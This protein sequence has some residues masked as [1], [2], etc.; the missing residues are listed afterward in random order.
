MNEHGILKG[1]EKMNV[2]GFLFKQVAQPTNFIRS[3][4]ETE[5]SGQALSFHALFTNKLDLTQTQIANDDLIESEAGDIE[6]LL[7]HIFSLFLDSE[8]LEKLFEDTMSEDEDIQGIL[9]LLPNELS[10]EERLI[11]SAKIDEFIQEN[12]Q[13]FN[14]L[15]GGSS[16]KR[17]LTDSLDIDLDVSMENL[18]LVPGGQLVAKIS[19]IPA[20]QIQKQF[21]QIFVEVEPILASVTNRQEVMKVSSKI[22]K[23]LEN[24][25]TL[26]KK[27]GTNSAF[28]DEKA[29][30]KE[31]RSW[32]QLIKTFQNRNQFVSKQQYNRSA[33][34]SST[35]IA[36][37]VTS[38]LGVEEASEVE[39]TRQHPLQPSATNMPI[40]KLEQ[41]VIHVNQTQHSQPVNQQL[42][43]R[44]QSIIVK[45][46]LLARN[47]GMNQLSIAL[48]PDNL[49]EMVVRLA[50]IN[51]EMTVRIIVTSTATREMLESNIHQLKNMFSP[52]QVIIE[53]QDPD[54]LKL[55]EDQEEQTFDKQNR[56]DQDQDQEHEEKKQ[57]ADEE[58]AV[59]FEQLLNE[60]V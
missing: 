21:Q 30:T 33:Q 20:Q 11:I 60:K 22:L 2:S 24:W 37:W 46:N 44:F 49:G 36:K 48:K 6:S 35:D 27:H 41:Y 50:Q 14:E 57:D 13:L 5:T 18:W 4:E 10:E 42:I 54:L 12:D 17:L 56:E 7:F 26:E 19:E 45:N 55:Q 8:E 38:L 31:Q 59:Q 9:S 3:L 28:L 40:S 34:V 51:G 43:E 16:L 53:K 15:E 23:L 39:L 58:F 32:Q 25:S 52:Q 29:T 1:G 47:G